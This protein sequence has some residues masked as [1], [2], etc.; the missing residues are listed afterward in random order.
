MFL[1]D[2]KDK[3][4]EINREKREGGLGFIAGIYS[5]GGYLHRLNGEEERSRP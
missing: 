5:K 3:L 4:Q 2:N 1:P